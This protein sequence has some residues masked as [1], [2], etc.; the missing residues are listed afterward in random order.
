MDYLKT[1]EEMKAE[2]IS[3]ANK[4]TDLE[5]NINSIQKKASELY[6]RKQELE[7]HLIELEEAYQSLEKK[8]VIWKQ[9]YKKIWIN[10]LN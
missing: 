7:N 3:D 9:I 1:I 10:F 5:L 8:N 2:K 4:I 6:D